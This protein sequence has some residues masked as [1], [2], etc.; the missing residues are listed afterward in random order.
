MTRPIPILPTTVVGSYP[1]P[2]WLV[3]QQKLRTRRVPRVR[4][5]EIWRVPEPF[6]EDSPA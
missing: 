6:L 3:D 4:A 2:G 5:P 1:Q